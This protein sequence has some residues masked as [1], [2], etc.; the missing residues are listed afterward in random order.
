MILQYLSKSKYMRGISCPRLLWYEVNR[1]EVMPPV[2]AGTQARF[3]MGHQVGD[4]AKLLYPN[5]VEIP[6][7][8]GHLQAVQETSQAVKRSVPIFEATFLHKSPGG[9]LLSRADILVPVGDGKWDMIEVKSSN[10][11]KDEHVEDVAFQLRVLAGAGMD[12]RKA[13]LMHLNSD[14]RRRGQVRA[15]DIFVKKNLTSEAGLLVEG[16]DERASKLWDMLSRPEPPGVDL[17]KECGNYRG[18]DLSGL[19]WSWLPERHVGEL[20]YGGRRALELMGKGI[21]RLADIP[22]EFPLS[23]KQE[24]QR[25][26]ALTG[27]PYLDPEEIAAFLAGLRYPLY[28]MDFETIQ[29]A[30]PLFDCM[31]TWQQ[32]PF[33]YSVHNQDAPAKSLRH[34]SFLADLDGG[35]RDPRPDFMTGLR[36][37]LGDKGSIL[38]YNAPFEARILRETAAVLPEHY[39]WV[40]GNVLPRIVDL[41]DLF[42]KFAY[43]HPEQAGSCS[44]KSVVPCVLGG[45]YEDLSISDGGTASSEYLRISLGGVD[46]DEDARVRKDLE[47]YCGKDTESLF[48]IIENL[49]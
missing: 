45:G 31:G 29:T 39:D 34:H 24:I 44:L 2:D 49:R 7:G 10:S 46:E 11:C 3:D 48:Q 25:E 4:L 42:R 12:I 19:C 1:P 43:Y 15:E 37:C 26:T 17:V 5:G 21:H 22:D 23:D 8:N 13:Y 30:I 28:A 47:M 6:W 27:S 40:H 35:L 33:Q 36:G 38:V 18:C 16:V 32:L 20:Y 9:P 14:Y 41:L